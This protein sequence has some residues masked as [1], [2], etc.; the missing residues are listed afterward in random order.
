MNTDFTR[1]QGEV[2][3]EK[4]FDSQRLP[5]EFEKEHAG[6]SKR[7]D[8]T[9]EWEGR[10]IVFDVKD[11]DPTDKFLTGFGQFDPYTPIREKINQGRDKF[12]QFKEYCCGLVLYNAGRPLIMIENVDIMLGT[13]YGDT[14]F[15]FPVNLDTG[16]GDAS[17][18]KQAF[19]G[20][21]KMVRP[22]WSQAQ[23]TTLSAIITLIRIKPHFLQLLDLVRENPRRSDEDNETEIRSR[24]P[25]FDSEFEVPRVI[26]WYN[27]VARTPFP[28]N[29]FRGEYDTHFGIVRAENGTVEQDVTFEGS[30]VPDRLKLFKPRKAK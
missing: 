6:K 17:Q 15:T 12:K 13:M 21:G 14:G 4:Y 5:F 9:I 10:T 30:S 18:L 1:T 26:V 29:L 27:A 16:V 22:N 11:F 25:N 2:V 23:N 3:F 19:L 28:T 20:R 7:P 24:I 8:Y